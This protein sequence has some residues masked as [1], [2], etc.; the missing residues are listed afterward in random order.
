MDMCW[1]KFD[2]DFRDLIV[3]S[4]V[5]CL[6]FQSSDGYMDNDWFDS[7]FEDPVLN[8]K[9]ITDAAQPPRIKS[10]HSYSINDTSVP[11]SPLGLGKLE[12]TQLLTV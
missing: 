7:L 8:D 12:G 11:S 6:Y 5:L 9:M 4:Q 1:H 2:R 3:F 10:E